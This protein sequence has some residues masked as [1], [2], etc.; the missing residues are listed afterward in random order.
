MKIVFT[1]TSKWRTAS[2]ESQTKFAPTKD[3]LVTSLPVSTNHRPSLQ[4][5]DTQK[6]D[7]YV[8]NM[9]S[10]ANSLQVISI[11]RLQDFDNER[12]AERFV[13]PLPSS[14][15]I[16]PLQDTENENK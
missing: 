6:T 5:L 9:K 1:P 12:R 15:S 10:R 11:K 16:S 3:I 8:Q 4:S 2:V 7:N 13:P 14:N